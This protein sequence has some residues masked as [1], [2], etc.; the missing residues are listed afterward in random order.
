MNFNLNSKDRSIYNKLDAN[1]RGKIRVTD[2]GCFIWTGS[3][4]RS[5]YGIVK[6]NQTTQAA[7]R[8]IYT[9]VV[10]PLEKEEH[11]HRHLNDVTTKEVCPRS[12]VNPNHMIITDRS[13]SF[14]LRRTGNHFKTHCPWG[15]A[16][17]EVNT[18]VVGSGHRKCKECHKKQSKEYYYSRKNKNLTKSK[19]SGSI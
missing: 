5:G 9:E 2:T 4:V 6:I 8:Y 7:H 17:D 16:Y 14:A 11:L 1:M 10:G 13:G 3:I 15:H 18:R 12:C 19:E